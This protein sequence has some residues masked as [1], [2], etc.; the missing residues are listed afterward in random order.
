[1][2]GLSSQEVKTIIEKYIGVSNGRL[3]NF[4][5]QTLT[6]F[7]PK[8]CGLKIDTSQHG[9]TIRQKFTTILQ[10]LPPHAQAKVVRGTLKKF[11]I[12]NQKKKPASRNK[13]LYEQLLDTI[14]GLEDVP[15]S[16]PKMSMGTA[17]TTN[18][19]V[20]ISYA[21][22]GNSEDFVNKLDKA[23]Q[24]KG[25]TIIR[26]KRDLGFKGRIKAFMERIGRG[27]AVIVV[28]SEKYLKSENCMFEL[29]Q[30]SKNDRFYDRIFPIVL[31]SANIYKSTK[32]IKYIQYWE[33]QIVEL[34]QALKTIGAANLQGFRE[35]IDLYTE[36][37]ATIANLMN[38]LR[39]MNTLSQELHADSDFN[40]LFQ[41]IKP[42]LTTTIDELVKAPSTLE[43]GGSSNES[44]SVEE[45]L[46]HLRLQVQKKELTVQHLRQNLVPIEQQ[47]IN[48]VEPDLH[49]AINWISSE[50]DRLIERACRELKQSKNLL[51]DNQVD[52][53]S[54]QLGQYLNLVRRAIIAGRNNLLQEPQT[55]LLPDVEPYA[56][57]IELIKTRIPED[58]NSSAQN[59]LKSRLDY[60]KGRL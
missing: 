36:I 60:L 46:E 43:N 35:D 57:A 8:Y 45:Q 6:S 15:K 22:G 47:L 58:M 11:P 12:T 48:G 26:D 40:D 29:V 50:K 55:S 41:A 42:K 32:R 7:Y 38:V 25:V 51:S 23:L 19:E 9:G 49:Q 14:Q 3:N 4:N 44:I 31:D 27:K 53:F 5:S 1:M 56:I 59:E 24:S 39:D 10:S 54:F 34:E 21:W 2:T 16:T 52:D 30:F 37:R 33:S 20:F 17:G 18:S 13:D 28:V